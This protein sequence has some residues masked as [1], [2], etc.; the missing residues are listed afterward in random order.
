MA[1]AIRKFMAGDAVAY[2]DT[3]RRL[4]MHTPGDIT[5]AK[6]RL[7]DRMH[8]MNLVPARLYAELRAHEHALNFVLKKQE[9]GMVILG[10][11]KEEA[12]SA[13]DTAAQDEARRKLE[14]EAADLRRHLKRAAQRENEL[15]AELV[16]QGQEVARLQRKLAQT[17]NSVAVGGVAMIVVL[18][19][20][21]GIIAFRG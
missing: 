10:D 15:E 20:L 12:E 5:A 1:E 6:E 4:I 9:P 16:V 11:A 18:L 19:V 21:F 8:E 17:Y 3:Y 14:E 7:L 13:V 2:V